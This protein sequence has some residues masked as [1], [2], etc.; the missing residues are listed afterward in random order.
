[1]AAVNTGLCSDRRLNQERRGQGVA[2]AETSTAGSQGVCGKGRSGKSGCV[3]VGEMNMAA[4]PANEVSSL[5]LRE[6]LRDV[7]I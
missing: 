2:P 3:R 4:G 1:M 7:I 5:Q 6:D